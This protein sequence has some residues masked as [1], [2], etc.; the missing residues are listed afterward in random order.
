MYSTKEGG[1]FFLNFYRQNKL[2]FLLPLY[3][4]SYFI[5][6]SDLII[7]GTVPKFIHWKEDVENWR[8]STERQNW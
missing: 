1:E 7:H 3:Y 2:Y 6:P 5:L 8:G 4:H